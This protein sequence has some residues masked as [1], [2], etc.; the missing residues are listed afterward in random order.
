ML[1]RSKKKMAITNPSVETSS[2]LLL[3][4]NNTFCIKV[5]GDRIIFSAYKNIFEKFCTWSGHISVPLTHDDA[6]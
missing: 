2:L 5:F 4:H 1:L 3:S 6:N